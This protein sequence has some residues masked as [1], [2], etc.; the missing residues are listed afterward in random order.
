MVAGLVAAALRC[1]AHFRYNCSVA[2]IETADGRVTGMRL[3]DGA[4]VPADIVV[5][6]R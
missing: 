3:A 5:S 2:G 4:D 6:N 1:G